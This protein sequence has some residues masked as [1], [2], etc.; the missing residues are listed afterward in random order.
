MNDAGSLRAICAP[1]DAVLPQA[2]Q[3]PLGLVLLDT[4][5]P[6]PMGDAGNP[7][8]W[9]VPVLTRV[10]PK[11]WPDQVVTSA[12]A[13]REGPLP[14]MFAQAMQDLAAQGAKAIT[15]SCGFLVLL[16]GELQAAVAV[17]VVTSSLLLLPRLLE[18][19]AQVGVLTIS[20]R[21]LSRDHLLRAGVP[22]RRLDDVVVEGV[23]PAGEFV[24]AILGNDSRMDLAAAERDVVA[25]ACALQRRAPAL[26]TLVLECTNM[27]PYARA[28]REATGLRVLSLFDALGCALQG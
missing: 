17:P 28:V 24:R 18:R 20:A 5:F 8:S 4:R 13:L 1:P 15:T 26:A 3:G 21:S 9:P 25:G 12:Q 23:D 22:P 19:E 16:Q 10:V 6:R 2:G 27:P 14:A 11:A 7:A